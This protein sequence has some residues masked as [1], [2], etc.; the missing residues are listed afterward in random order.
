MLYVLQWEGNC[1]LLTMT[2]LKELVAPER[3]LT[4][5]MESG[6]RYW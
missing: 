6:N 5:S 1:L 4:L 2:G 3:V